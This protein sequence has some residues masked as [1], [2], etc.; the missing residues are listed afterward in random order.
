M[1]QERVEKL[2]SLVDGPQRL[3]RWQ[4]GQVLPGWICRE[5][6]LG[7]Y[8]AR[9]YASLIPALRGHASVRLL[10]SSQSNNLLQLALRLRQEGIRPVYVQEGR[11][12]PLRGNGLFS[13][14]VLGDGYGAESE[15]IREIAEG[16]SCVESLPGALTMA[17]SMAENIAVH[18]APSMIFIEAGSGF[19][20]AALIFGMAFLG[21]QIPLKVV[22]LG[23]ARGDFAGLLAGWRPA[24]LALLGEIGPLPSWEILR[25]PTARSFGSINRTILGEVV[26]LAQEEGL[27]VDPIYTAKLTLTARSFPAPLDSLIY[28][29]G[30]PLELCGFQE[31]LASL[32]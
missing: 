10:G 27:L 32:M 14:I 19:S 15:E 30:G 17:A 22:W 9:K 12:G 2:W 21:L 20:A 24:A 28:C 13:R 23:D 3:S 5:D 31:Q 26:R 6:E 7:G 25:P 4:K 8:K 16:A 11:P 18:G 1:D 29:G